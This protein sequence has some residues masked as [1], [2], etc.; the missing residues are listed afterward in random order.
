[1]ASDR[2]G[3]LRRPALWLSLLAVGVVLG[4]GIGVAVGWRAAMERSLISA[5][6]RTLERVDLEVDQIVA[7]KDRWKAYVRS[8]DDGGYLELSG[9]E[10]TFLLRGESP[11][12]VW[13]DGEGDQLDAILTV[14]AGDGCYNV[15][16]A[17][18]I[19]VAGGLAIMDVEHLEV[20]GRDLSDLAGLGGA[21]GGSKQAVSP[22]D[23]EDPEVSAAL[24]NIETLEVVD[25]KL[26]IRFVDPSKVWQ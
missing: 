5:R 9:R 25:S 12:G 13:L 23:I 8:R 4:V 26:R 2:P 19:A 11:V 18:S 17:G 24:A 20:G 3:L 6:C 1:M 15:E 16:F 7:L 10:A 22:E 14:P 21:L